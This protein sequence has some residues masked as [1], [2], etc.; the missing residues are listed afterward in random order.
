MHMWK[1]KTLFF[2]IKK[3]EFYS[4]FG[5]FLGSC[6]AEISGQAYFPCVHFAPLFLS[7]FLDSCWFLMVRLIHT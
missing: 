6:L 1:H 7:H 5:I 2:Y 4:H 3:Q